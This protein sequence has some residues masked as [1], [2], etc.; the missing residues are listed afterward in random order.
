MIL[1]WTTLVLAK[2]L[3]YDLNEQILK[4]LIESLN[5]TSKKCS[6]DLNDVMK[7]YQ[8]RKPWAIA[9]MLSVLTELCYIR[10]II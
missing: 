1:S 10:D 6:K 4:S 9:S 2:N 5:A 7:G 3:N 8:E